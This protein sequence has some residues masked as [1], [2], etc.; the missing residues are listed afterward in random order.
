VS[1][2]LSSLPRRAFKGAA[3]VCFALASFYAIARVSLEPNDPSRGVGVIFAPWVSADEAFV[4]SV[5]AGS[6]FVRYGSFPFIVVVVPEVDDY[7][8]R[9]TFKGALLVVDPLVLEACLSSISRGRG[10]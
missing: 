9:T 4:R 10:S 6:R 7:S 1:S 8:A 3:I 5:E 2:F